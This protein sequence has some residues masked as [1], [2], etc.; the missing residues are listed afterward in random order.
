M[1]PRS[2]KGIQFEYY[3]SVAFST[4][5]HPFDLLTKHTAYQVTTYSARVQI[6]LAT[7]MSMST[8][9]VLPSQGLRL[10]ARPSAGGRRAA[11]VVRAEGKDSYQVCSMCVKL[12]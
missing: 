7:M 2:A 10:P 4:H 9:I 8:R 5:K 12:F 6:S 1:R 3:K 11:L